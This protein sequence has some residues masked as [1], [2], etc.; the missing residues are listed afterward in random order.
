MSES[1]R[2]SQERAREAG[3]GGG[4]GGAGGGGGGGGVGGSLVM[5]SHCIYLRLTWYPENGGTH[6]SLLH[7][8]F[9]QSSSMEVRCREISR[10]A[11]E[12]AGITVTFNFL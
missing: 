9:F 2:N 5:C 4:G 3:A 1:I 6:P 12:A 11:N 7:A 10:H 8:C